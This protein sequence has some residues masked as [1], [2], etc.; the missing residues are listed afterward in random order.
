M[1]VE[2][3]CEAEALMK[4]RTP[5]PPVIILGRLPNGDCYQVAYDEV[6]SDTVFLAWEMTGGG[7]HLLHRAVHL[8]GRQGVARCGMDIV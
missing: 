1:S 4:C 6:F 3:A 2:G 7:L 5:G 8:N